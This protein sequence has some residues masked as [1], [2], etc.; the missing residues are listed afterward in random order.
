MAHD[1]T[2][3]GWDLTAPADT[4]VARNGPRE[5]RDLRK[6]VDLRMQKEHDPA[7]PNTSGFTHRPGSARAYYQPTPSPTKTPDGS[8]TLSSKDQGRLWIDPTT[9]V[10]HFWNG[11]LWQPVSIAA[12]VVLTTDMVNTASIQNGAVTTTKIA[13]GAVTADRLAPNAVTA[14]A[15]LAGSITGDKLANGSIPTTKLA[16]GL[17][18]A[19]PAAYLAEEKAAGV[20]PTLPGGF[21]AN[22]WFTRPLT[23]KS[24]RQNVLQAVYPSGQF[25]LGPGY[26][27][28][29]GGACGHDCNKFKVAIYNATDAQT[30]LVGTVANSNSGDDTNS[31]SSLDGEIQITRATVLGLI[32]LVTNASG[33]A[34]GQ[35]VGFET[36]RYAY[37]TIEKVP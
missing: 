29:R 37:L 11:S 31:W 28:L 23:L 34:W 10:L 6:G 8:T 26:Y 36:E 20:A 24:N 2:G 7:G 13:P 1:G 21:S 5:I 22:N 3:T 19:P 32:Q 27:R 15:I 12:G 17:Q 9:K 33:T 16:P 30:M 14:A 25:Q 4:D 35:P 18:G